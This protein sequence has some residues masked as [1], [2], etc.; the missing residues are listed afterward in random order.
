MAAAVAYLLL[1][2]LVIIP[3]FAGAGHYT[4]WGLFGQVTA[5]ALVE[6]WF[7]PR[8]GFYLIALAAPLLP[9]LVHGR[10]VLLA[11]V[12]TLLLVA[13]LQNAD[14]LNIKYWHQSSMLPVLFLAATL[15]VTAVPQQVRRNGSTPG[16]NLGPL[17]GLLMGVLCFQQWMGVSPWARSYALVAGQRSAAGADPRQAAVDWVRTRFAPAQT[18]VLATERLAAHFFDYRH[19]EPLG[20]DLAVRLA[21][22]PQV[23]VIDRSDRWDRLV[24]SERIEAFLA[25]ARQAGYSPAYEAGA[26]AILSSPAVQPASP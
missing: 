21:S 6:R 11:A 14:Y 4:R 22:A 3:G 20:D 9:A 5:R 25:A 15:G 12:P 18:T 13:A 19:V 17:L 24:A 16:L 10:R 1:C 26:V 8:V 7:R 2:V 23:L